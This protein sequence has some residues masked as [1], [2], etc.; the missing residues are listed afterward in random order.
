MNS[1]GYK[2]TYIYTYLWLAQTF[3]NQIKHAIRNF[4]VT[5]PLHT[6]F[7]ISPSEQSLT[8]YRNCEKLF[9]NSE[10]TTFTKSWC[11]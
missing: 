8:E 4:W 3:G 11:Y 1:T 2:K 7:V 5:E 6:Y 10:N 9:I